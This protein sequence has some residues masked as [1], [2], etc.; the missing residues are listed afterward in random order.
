[1]L[2]N[3]I[4]TKFE[5]SDREKQLK[6]QFF[7]REEEPGKKY[8][9][10]R[11]AEQNQSLTSENQINTKSNFLNNNPSQSVSIE[12]NSK[13]FRSTAKTVNNNEAKALNLMNTNTNNFQNFQNQSYSNSV[14]EMKNI[15]KEEMKKFYDEAVNY[16]PKGENG[17]TPQQ[18]N[19]LMTQNKIMQRNVDV[20]QETNRSLQDFIIYTM[21]KDAMRPK[22]NENNSQTERKNYENLQKALTPLYNHIENLQNQVKE[23]NMKKRE[24]EINIEL[25]D[26]IIKNQKNYIPNEKSRIIQKKT[27]K[28]NETEKNNKI[29]MKTLT[30]LK[31]TMGNMTEEMKKI[32]A[33]FNEK[34]QK[35]LEDT[36]KNKLKSIA[37][38]SAKITS[39]NTT[40]NL[41]NKNLST[42]NVNSNNIS[43]RNNES[44]LKNKPE[45]ID[46]ESFKSDLID[47]GHIKDAIVNDYKSNMPEFPKLTKP[48]G[49][50]KFTYNLDQELN[51]IM[52]KL[53]NR[54][55]SKPKPVSKYDKNKSISMKENVSNAINN[56]ENGKQRSKSIIPNNN[57]TSNNKKIIDIPKND[58]NKD[59][60][61][62]ENKK[63]NDISIVDKMNLYKERMA[64][65]TDQYETTENKPKIQNEVQSL[66][67]FTSNYPVEMGS[68]HS[69]VTLQTFSKPQNPNNS[70][71][72][73]KNQKPKYGVFHGPQGVPNYNPNFF[74]LNRD[75]PENIPINN[76]N[77]NINIQQPKPLIIQQPVL[78]NPED[79]NKIIKNTIDNYIKSAFS[80]LNP[81]N[82]PKIEINQKPQKPNTIERVIEK[83]YVT[84]KI[85]EIKEVPK[86]PYQ[87]QINQNVSNQDKLLMEKLVNL[88]EKFTNIEEKITK[89]IIEK[90]IIQEKVIEKEVQRPQKIIQPPPEKKVIIPNAD[91]ISKLVIDKIKKQMNIDINLVRQPP[92]QPQP[93]PIINNVQP[94]KE[95]PK[96]EII[97]TF[98]VNNKIKIEDLD[99]IIRM[100]HRINLEEYEVSQTSSYIS[101]SMANN[102]IKNIGEN[103]NIEY[104]KIRINANQNSYRNQN[105]IENS[106]SAGEVISNDSRSENN[107]F[108]EINNRN[109][110]IN[111]TNNRTGMDLMML[112]NLNENLQNK[113]QMIQSFKP[114]HP[115]QELDN[116]NNAAN[117]NVNIPNSSDG[118][119]RS[120]VKFVNGVQTN[121]NEVNKNQVGNKSSIEGSKDNFFNDSG[122]PH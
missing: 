54:N 107:N 29:M 87:P 23:L 38:I 7:K 16:L 49:K 63:L 96:E 34:M 75:Q 68:N 1:M 110:I 119:Y 19:L 22:N 115:D 73:N 56:N 106:V 59:N 113:I 52:N 53:D 48:K 35:V 98:D 12:Q 40:N 102:N 45:Q 86:E 122:E 67:P 77:N 108:N 71:N 13:I 30:N 37:G 91:L 6:R 120:Y 85:Q 17:M 11:P 21:K 9:F 39:S 36:E 57:I 93:Q 24:D 46:Y 97:P 80:N 94:K 101:E 121:S 88:T 76:D 42:L 95:Q 32:G 92:Q 90:K 27:Q 118:N 14:P 61:D 82:A 41:K 74:G 111:N 20:L 33:N 26:L 47:I 51:K 28:Q 89:E 69:N 72:L 18:I 5:L 50:I 114:N 66:N 55:K 116:L 78:P 65:M 104:N 2:D 15:T 3:T 103:V 112:K 105:D 60:F 81:E 99:E 70:N 44:L 62:K 79:L 43:N 84:N 58:I 83:E 31:G 8:L 100:P 64:K 4:I 10:E 25:D 117:N 109:N